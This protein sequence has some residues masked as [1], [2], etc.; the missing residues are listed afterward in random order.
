[1][2]KA[3]LKAEYLIDSDEKEFDVFGFEVLNQNPDMDGT[4]PVRRISDG[5]Y[6]CLPLYA[7]QLGKSPEIRGEFEIDENGCLSVVNSMLVS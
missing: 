2:I 7:I 1:M 3:Y 5:Q 6:S 4:I